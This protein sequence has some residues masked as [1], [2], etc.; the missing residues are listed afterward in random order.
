MNRF[1]DARNK[2]IVDILN[3]YRIN[4]S[5]KGYFVCPFCGHNDAS[6][7]YEDNRFKCFHSSCN[8]SGSTVDFVS[9]IENIT[10]VEAVNKI[11]DGKLSFR[12]YNPDFAI[13][14]Q[15]SNNNL[16]KVIQ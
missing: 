11:L 2:N 14:K 3:H 1:E 5:R 16:K 13:E 12:K 15:K 9:K 10:P 4:V 6:I 7:N 8:E